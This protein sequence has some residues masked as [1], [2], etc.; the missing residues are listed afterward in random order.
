MFEEDL[1][2]TCSAAYYDEHIAGDHSFNNLIQKEYISDEQDE[3]SLNHW[4]RYH[5]RKQNPPL[6]I[7][8]RV[9]SHQAVINAMK[10]GMGI[11]MTSSH[12]IWKALRAK[13]LV[14]INTKKRNQINQISLVQLQNRKPSM[15]EK[16]FLAYFNKEMEQT[17][18]I[19]H[20]YK[21]Q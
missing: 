14:I 20:I 3:L 17:S 13:E 18:D 15:T 21:G 1:I 9:E 6:N 8:L 12:F 10:Q 2:L 5:H 7:V 4:F 19:R 16:T 11:G